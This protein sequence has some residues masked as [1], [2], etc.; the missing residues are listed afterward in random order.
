MMQRNLQFSI[1]SSA[2]LDEVDKKKSKN[3][4]KHEVR[5]TTKATSNKQMKNQH[6]TLVHKRPVVNE[7]HANTMK[8]SSNP[9]PSIKKLQ[10]K[11]KNERTKDNI[12]TP[13]DS[14]MNKTSPHVRGSLT[15]K[16]ESQPR[17]PPRL[18]LPNSLHQPFILHN[19]SLRSLLIL[20][21]IIELYNH[22]H[23]QQ[24]QPNRYP[25]YV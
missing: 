5:T 11:R 23:H 9:D 8:H 25:S 4:Q 1:R 17:R 22:H 20:R 7:N 10:H 13:N 12:P 14:N 2:R 16:T 18:N 3:S 15:R 19:L 24:P 21:P 6:S